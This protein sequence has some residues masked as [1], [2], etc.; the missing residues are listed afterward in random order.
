MGSMYLAVIGTLLTAAA[1]AFVIV[2]S[3]AA[4]RD[5]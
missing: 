2:K 1:V 3:R 4:V 5:A